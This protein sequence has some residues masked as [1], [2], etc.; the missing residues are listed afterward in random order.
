M[1]ASDR[2]DA[3]PAQEVEITRPIAVIEI[4][5]LALLETNVVADGL[6]HADELLVEM[7]R[8]HGAALRLA[9][10]KHLGNV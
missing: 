6:E 2:E 7:A 10:H 5:P 3:K 9:L 4:L 1:I 8:M